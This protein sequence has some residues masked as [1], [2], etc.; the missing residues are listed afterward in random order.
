[1][2]KPSFTGC[3][4]RPRHVAIRPVA[5]MWRPAANV[6]LLNVT[7]FASLRS[8]K[9]LEDHR[10]SLRPLRNA[11]ARSA[12]ASEKPS[13]KN[14]TTGTAAC[15]PRARFT[16]AASSRPPPP[17]S[18]MNSRRLLPST[19]LRPR[20]AREAGKGMLKWGARHLTQDQFSNSRDRYRYR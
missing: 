9:F 5:L 18:A 3:A 19:L 11:T 12:G 17:S 1:M 10:T 4:E 2:F 7:A 20:R 6:Q 14:P 8:H 15:C 13:W 16:L